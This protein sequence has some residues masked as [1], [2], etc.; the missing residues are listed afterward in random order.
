MQIIK[1]GN[2]VC[3]RLT[4]G[5]VIMSDSI[6]ENEMLQ[7]F[8]MSEDEIKRKFLVQYEEYAEAVANVTRSVDSKYVTFQ[9]GMYLIP[10]ISEIS[11]PEDLA[12][13]LLEA[14]ENEDEN[15]IETYLNFWTLCCQNPNAEARNNLLWF[16]DTH[17]FKILKSGMF[18]A[19]RNV[20]YKGEYEL[21][22]IEMTEAIELF[23]HIKFNRESPKDYVLIRVNDTI[24][25][26]TYID[27]VEMKS[28]DDVTVDHELLGNLSDIVN[29]EFKIDEFTDQRTRQMKIQLGV[30]VRIPR[31]ECDE[32]SSVSC[33]RGLHL[34]RKDWS[35]LGSFGDTTMV[36]LCNPT[37]VVAV[38]REDDYGKIRCCEYFP[39]ELTQ[40]DP[41]TG[42]IVETIQDGD[43]L[44]Y[45]NISYDGLINSEKSTEFQLTIPVK[46]E[47]NYTDILHSLNEI[48]LKLIE[49][50]Q[51]C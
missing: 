9:N 12:E 39:V 19:Y 30:P 42:A 21:T 24:N 2:N 47:I 8:E 51:G 4:D 15:L 13:K 3:I 10:D 14:E 16:L 33:S 49:K 29:S 44:P 18:V 45:F 7:I 32:D 5:T 46:P 20:V 50:K 11:V 22:D 6:T 36:C 40:K 43:E 31:E 41:V 26:N 38:P 23:S 37:N 1:T 48:K 27:V 17:G 28:Y 34:A 25:R 35:G